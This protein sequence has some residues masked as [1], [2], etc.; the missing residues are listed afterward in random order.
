LNQKTG[1]RR[2]V[3][4]S[5]PA[6]SI[7]AILLALIIGGAGFYYYY[8]ASAD[9]QHGPL[10]IATGPKSGTY[11]A[12]GKALKRVLEETGQ[13]ESVTLR[14]T[15]GSVENS[16]LIGIRD[17][18]TDLAYI[19]EDALPAPNV[20][21]IASLY[22]EV[23]HIMTTTA[24][25]ETIKTI[26]DL[27]GSRVSLG[28][29]GS[30]T[31]ELARRVLMH[32]GVTVGQGLALDPL[33]TADA[34]TS[35]DIDA[36]FLLSAIPS[37]LVA[38]LAQRDR[39][40]FISLGE[41]DATGD[42]AHALERVFPGVRQDVI[43]RSTY[44]RLPM[45]PVHTVGV[46]AMLVARA[47]LDEDTVRTVTSSIFEH[48]GDSAGLEGSAL[49]V[50]QTIRENYDPSSVNLP[51]HPG[52]AAYYRREEPPFLVEYAETLSFVV[53]VILGVYSL[54][55]ALRQWLRRRLKNR[56]D[57]YLLEVERLADGAATLD[58][59][60]LVD[61]RDALLALRRTVFDDLVAERLSA[62]HGFVILQNHLRDELATIDTHIENRPRT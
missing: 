45:E 54:S 31:R 33:Q 9:D 40:R 47:D 57:A 18:N 15:D 3:G 20:R 6:K 53:T 11:E 17:G 29:P 5:I 56:V 50:A 61:R 16:K 60:G 51:Y 19:Q 42:E 62:D 44:I 34:L 25:A 12:M 58:L 13:F 28:S 30:G 37:D 21:L 8:Q 32:F 39:I 36:A 52:A 22:D 43:P 59:K 26:Y 49:N 23:L 14:A 7:L 41:V 38:G 46:A 10:V 48:R 1:F 24:S 55:I 2:D 35:G 4:A 27:E